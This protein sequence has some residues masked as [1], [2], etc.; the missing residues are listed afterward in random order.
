MVIPCR[1]LSSPGI[2]LNKHL[3]CCA[4]CSY[5]LVWCLFTIYP[6]IIFYVMI[7]YT[8]CWVAFRF[9]MLV[10]KMWHTLEESIF[11]SMLLLEVHSSLCPLLYY[12]CFPIQ[13][14]HLKLNLVLINSS[15]VISLLSIHLVYFVHMSVILWCET[16]VMDTSV[17]AI[18]AIS[19]V[20]FKSVV[21]LLFVGLYMT[22]IR[23]NA[24]Y[25]ANNL[26]SCSPIV[27]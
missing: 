7:L 24:S 14:V 26:S 12:S 17:S 25:K 9:I 5:I 27:C 23:L 13:F 15:S 6:G 21:L 2:A 19:F 16:L 11:F 22:W 1:F 3:S 20:N 10:F 4:G 18:I 8:P